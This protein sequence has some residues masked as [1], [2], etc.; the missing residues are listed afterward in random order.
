MMVKNVAINKDSVYKVS[1]SFRRKPESRLNEFAWIPARAALGRD[2]AMGICASLIRSAVESAG[3]V[4]TLVSLVMLLAFA[5]IPQDSVF[6]QSK[7]LKEVRV[8]YALGGSTGF[9]WVAQRSGSFEKHGLKVLP[10]FMRGGREAVQ[11][12]ISRDV[13]MLQQGSSGV[14]LAWAQGAKDLVV[15][16]ANSPRVHASHARPAGRY[17]EGYGKYDRQRSHALDDEHQ[18]RRCDGFI[19][20]DTARRRTEKQKMT[21]QA[22]QAVQNVQ[23]VFRMVPAI[24]TT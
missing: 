21:V 22:V 1:R 5:L 2:D 4:K 9:F 6:A 18:R 7:P 13:T 3:R 14:I 17:V 10:I 16:G 19:V 15:L 8:P 12:L 23:G 24:L 20:S 11:A